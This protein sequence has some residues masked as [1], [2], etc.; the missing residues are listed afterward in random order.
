MSRKPRLTRARAAQ[1]GV[2]LGLEQGELEADFCY[3]G[4]KGWR[5]VDEINVYVYNADLCSISCRDGMIVPYER[6][7]GKVRFQNS[8][9]CVDDE[10]STNS[11]TYILILSLLLCLA[12]YQ[13][14]GSFSVGYRFPPS[15]LYRPEG[16][17]HTC[18]HDALRN[19]KGNYFS[20]NTQLQFDLSSR[21]VAD[22]LA[23]YMLAH[24]Q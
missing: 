14:D 8:Y 24:S 1:G 5:N 10:A 9:P 7:N 6:M 17:V 23:I 2:T 20:L 22:I 18:G 11:A 4:F 3:L 15:L 12:V 13:K 21:A 16:C 19:S